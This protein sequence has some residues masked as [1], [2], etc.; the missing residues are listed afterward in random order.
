MSIVMKSPSLEVFLWACAELGLDKKRP[1]DWTLAEFERFHSIAA[2]RESPPSHSMNPTI[3]TRSGKYFNFL[4]PD[5][6]SIQ[7]TDIAHALS[8]ICRYTGHVSEIY[9]V[10]QHSVLVSQTVPQRDGLPFMGL[11]HDATEAYVGDMSRPLKLLLPE[12]QEIEARV[13]RAIALKFNLPVEL[14]PEIKYADNVLLFT[15]RRDLMP[16]NVLSQDEWAWGD[17]VPRLPKMIEPWSRLRSKREFL[18][19]FWDLVQ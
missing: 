8:N 3:M 14:P 17:D 11:M 2:E 5:P 16:A 7:I 9:D 13:W 6:M 15:E 4:D 12:Y 1:D 10:A 18:A 19:R